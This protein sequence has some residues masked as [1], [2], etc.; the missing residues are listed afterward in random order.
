[1]RVWTSDGRTP[2]GARG[3]GG[4]GAGVAGTTTAAGP[5]PGAILGWAFGASSNSLMKACFSVAH[6]CA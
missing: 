5:A 4:R 1:M 3:A 6:H 2:T